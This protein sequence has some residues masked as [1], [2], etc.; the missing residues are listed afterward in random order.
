MENNKIDR[1]S[2]RGAATVKI[3]LVFVVL[4]AVAHAGIN[5]IPVA[6]NGAS[7]RQEMDTAVVK[8][9]SAPGRLKPID[10]VAA[11]V[12]KASRDHHLP[13]DAYIEIGIV[14]GVIEAQV[15]YTEKV[16][17]LPFGLYRHDYKF[18]YVARPTGY[19]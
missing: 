3:L 9:L 16:N 6:Y 4:A 5:Y 15:S 2:E 19:L 13:D 17:I 14:D 7:L 1:S 18:D 11:S 10:I 8:G 12:Q